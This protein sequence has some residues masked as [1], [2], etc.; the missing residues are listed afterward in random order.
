MWILSRLFLVKPQ[1]NELFFNGR[2]KNSFEKNFFF[3]D[4][5]PFT[6]KPRLKKKFITSSLTFSRTHLGMYMLPRTMMTGPAMNHNVKKQK[7]G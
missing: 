3:L 2:A 5:R 6:P 4:G 7:N 1:K